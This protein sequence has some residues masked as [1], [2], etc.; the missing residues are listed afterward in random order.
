[1]NATV[2]NNSSR[3]HRL[4]I[5]VKNY[6]KGL[7]VTLLGCRLVFTVSIVC[8]TWGMDGANMWDM[9]LKPGPTDGSSK[10]E[11]LSKLYTY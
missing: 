3:E 6:F 10:M 8:P 11:H 1:M 4:F 2:K 5:G 7:G 9:S